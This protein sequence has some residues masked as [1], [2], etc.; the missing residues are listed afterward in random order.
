MIRI[1]TIFGFFLPA[2]LMGQKSY[3]LLF[4]SQYINDFTPK[5]ELKF[6]SREDLSDYLIQ[7]RNKKIEKGFVLS[8]IDEVEWKND[9]AYVN[10]Y[11]GEKFDQINISFDSQDAYII[12]KIPRMSERMISK[13]PFQPHLVEELLGG[14]NKYLNQNGYP[15]SK[16]FLKIDTLQPGISTAH[17]HIEKGTLVTIKKIELKGSSKVREKFIHNVISIREGDLYDIQRI[18]NISA[19]IE[20]IQFIKE[21]RKHELLFTPAGAELYLYLESVPVSL[22]NGIVGL[23][24]NP[25]TGK[26]TF[27]GDVRLKLLNVIQRGEELQV[28][29]KS[30]KP[31]TQ[32]LDVLFNFPFFFN[33]PFGIDTKFDL[34]K[35]DSIFLTTN[36][37][38]GV[39]YFLSGGS[40]IKMFYQAENSN[41]LSGASSIPNS[42]FSSLSSNSYGLGIFRNNVDYLPNPSKGF[43]MSL[44]IAAGRRKSKPTIED[45]VSVSTTFKG[46]LSMEMF[47]P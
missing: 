38:L 12:S 7:F 25:T 39:R 4:N 30:L 40:Y 33:T 22:F 6:N 9:T 47:I 41:L 28:N 21:I 36:V 18:K 27:T 15:F 13:L 5:K 29:W 16:V 24:P 43:R 35:Q 11:L 34:Y 42:N 14:I 32:E 37:H 10:F 46:N 2:L 17:L 3:Y 8:S 20:Q 31:K 19:K 23:Q 44:D 26:T 1:I 45:T